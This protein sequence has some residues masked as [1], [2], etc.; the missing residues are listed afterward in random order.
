[1]SD[2]VYDWELPA[3]MANYRFDLDVDLDQS[4]GTIDPELLSL[5]APNGDQDLDPAA[6]GLRPSDAGQSG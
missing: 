2:Y 1:M 4:S 3:D 5:H 6:H